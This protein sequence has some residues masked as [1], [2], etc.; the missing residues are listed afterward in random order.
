MLVDCMMKNSILI[1]LAIFACCRGDDSLFTP[2]KF[3]TGQIGIDYIN[4]P[5]YSADP[6]SVNKAME[7][8][9]DKPYGLLHTGH[10]PGKDAVM[11]L[12]AYPRNLRAFRRLVGSLRATGY[13]GHIILG[14]SAKIPMIEENYLIKMD[15]TM[16]KVDIINCDESISTGGPVKGNIRGKCARG[17]EKL[18]L[19][20]GRYEMARQWLYACKECT[21]WTLVMDTRDVFFQST[22]FASLGDAITSPID[23]YFVEEIAPH[24]SPDPNPKRSFI[25]GNFRNRAHTVPCYGEEKYNEYSQRPVLCSGTVIGNRDGMLRF[26]SVLVSEFYSNNAKENLKCRSPVTT[27]QWTMN[28][29]YYTGAFGYP[30]KTRT[31]P[32]G[33]GPVNTVGKACKTL[34]RKD[35]ATDIVRR[36]D[37]GLIRNV[38]DNKI[39]PVVHQFDRCSPWIGEYF[40]QHPELVGDRRG[41]FYVDMVEPMKWIT[42]EAKSEG[43][44][45][46]MVGE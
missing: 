23:L 12:A 25:A 8:A 21:G 37:K 10:P 45:T 1:F 28:W 43:K 35:G 24:T 22:P 33:I 42:Q 40:T 19:E 7:L 4:K 38:H 30:E 3:K 6:G 26:L 29:L 2:N 31:L 16:Y 36:D 39:S 15:V 41:K 9:I 14:V 34:Q 5:L 18:K 44:K 11:G 20:W 32:W 27:D 46:E 13:D 17:L